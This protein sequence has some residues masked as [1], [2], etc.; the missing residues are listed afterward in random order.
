MYG[1]VFCLFQNSPV[2]GRIHGDD[3]IYT[4]AVNIPVRRSTSSDGS[5]LMLILS[6]NQS[7]PLSLLGALQTMDVR[8]RE[9]RSGA[10]TLSDRPKVS[11]IQAS[12]LACTFL[13]MRPGDIRLF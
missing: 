10:V 12:S 13:V 5:D 3:F 6:K 9:R 4:M 8:S 11:G 7:I 2:I 1:T